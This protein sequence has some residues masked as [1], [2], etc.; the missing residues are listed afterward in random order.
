MKL[1]AIFVFISLIY[2]IQATIVISEIMANPNDVSDSNGEWFEIYNFSDGTVNLSGYKIRRIGKTP[3]EIS[4]DIYVEA[5]G[6][7]VFCR[8]AEPSETNGYVDGDYV[9]DGSLGLLNTN[10]SIA[11]LDAD[12]NTESEVFYSSSR[13]GESY[14]RLINSS[15]TTNTWAYSENRTGY[16]DDNNGQYSDKGSPG[17][18]HDA[19]DNTLPVELSSFTVHQNADKRAII[20]WITQSETGCAGFYILRSKNEN[21]VCANRISSLISAHNTEFEQ[22]YEFEDNYPVQKEKNYYWLEDYELDGSSI[23]YGPILLDN[24][25]EET[26]PESNLSSQLKA[27]YPNPFYMKSTKRVNLTFEFTTGKNDNCELVIYNLLGQQVKKWELK[28][29]SNTSITWN[30]YNRHNEPQAAGIY[31]YVFKANSKIERG[32][33]LLIK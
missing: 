32:K 10:G 31:F 21:Q 33:I 4:S 11:I 16:T 7:A 8:I 17:L 19:P 3:V 28:S 24:E 23:Y 30:G 13:A 1:G 26:V 27:V 5:K 25:D 14:Y 15:D 29:D 9:L 22:V 20:R 6:Y 12:G 18:A 2:S